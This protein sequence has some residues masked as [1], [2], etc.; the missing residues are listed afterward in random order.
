MDKEEK[1]AYM[2]EWRR[3]NPKKN[4]EYY[5][6]WASKNPDKISEYN[7]RQYLRRKAMK[8]GGDNG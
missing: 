5:K 3:K 1:A 6:N 2:R 7:H 4:K 8:G